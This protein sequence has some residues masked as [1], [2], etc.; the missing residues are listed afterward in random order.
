MTP[1]KTNYIRLLF[2][3]CI[4]WATGCAYIPDPNPWECDM[5]AIFPSECLHGPWVGNHNS[6][7][8]SGD[9]DNH[10]GFMMDF[11]VS[12]LLD[13]EMVS[14]KVYRLIPRASVFEQFGDDSRLV[15]E[16]Y[17]QICAEYKALLGPEPT[18]GFITTIYY[19]GGLVI[20]A[21]TDFAGIPA[22]ENIAPLAHLFPDE[23]RQYTPIPTISVPEDYFPLRMYSPIKFWIEDHKVVKQ[24]VSLHVE[25]PV[26]LGMM[27]T[28]LHDRL[29]D[30][31]AQMQFKDEV[32]VGDI[33]IPRGLH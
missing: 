25:L 13:E 11:S 15:K 12:L 21:D 24:E 28:L 19:C 14:E 18:D 1:M 9:I 5:V 6:F 2:A 30:P 17:D 8:I 22:G 10:L 7:R 4:L 23:I 27:L 29:T 33:L 3:T 31:N 26:K 32:L 20:T 16:A